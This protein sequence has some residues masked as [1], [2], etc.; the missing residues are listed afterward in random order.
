MFLRSRENSTRCDLKGET[1]TVAQKSVDA[2]SFPDVELQS[3]S[4]RDAIISRQQFYQA[5]SDWL[6]AR[7]L[8]D[9]EESC[10]GSHSSPASE[11]AI[12][13]TARVWCS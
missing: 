7:L 2:G 4:S 9:K 3:W 1:Y 10:G 6:F 13:C 5:I 8:T 12:V 11:V